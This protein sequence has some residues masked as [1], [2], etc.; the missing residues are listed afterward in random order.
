MAKP[1][2]VGNKFRIRPL[3]KGKRLSENYD[4]LNT[5]LVAIKKYELENLEYK[6]GFKKVY[7]TELIFER[8][9][10]HWIKYRLPEKRKIKD[11]LSMLGKYL[12]PSFGKMRIKDITVGGI[13]DFKL[14]LTHLKP[15]TQYNILALLR[16]MLNYAHD[17]EWIDR[18]PKV[19]MPKINVLDSEYSYLKTVR[20]I[21][22]FIRSCEKIDYQLNV[23]ATTAIYT[24]MRQGELAGLKWED[25]DFAHNQIIVKRS[26]NGP[27]KNGKTRIV[28]I[29]SILLPVLRQWRLQNPQGYV[30]YNEIGNPLFPCHSFFQ[31]KFKLALDE[32]GFKRRS[33]NKH[34]IVFHDLRHTFA[35]HW[36]M[37]GGDIYKLKTILGHSDTKMTQ[38]YAHLSPHVFQED[39]DIFDHPK[40][41]ST[42]SKLA[43]IS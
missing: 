24:G 6:A 41:G 30:F 15:K 11:D 7:S 9:S 40:T 12:S 25:I 4:D 20:E 10:E 13:E 39:L 21:E 34:Y 38:R 33:K 5:A 16:A 28:P 36:M 23:L 37:K 19:R 32:A 1:I 43:I 31:E 2:K 17:H 26:F 27:T 8:L 3:V 18:V 14:T 29:L 35:S 22:R 42:A